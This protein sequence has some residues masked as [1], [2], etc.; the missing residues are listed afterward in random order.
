MWQI[1]S[2]VDSVFHYSWRETDE[3]FCCTGSLVKPA[4]T[5]IVL[6]S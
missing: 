3:F 2:G 4:V 1:P 6:V 5:E